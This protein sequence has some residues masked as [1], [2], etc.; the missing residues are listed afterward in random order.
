[1]N[2]QGKLEL[3]VQSFSSFM[4][5]HLQSFAAN[6]LT[7]EVVQLLTERG[8]MPDDITFIIANPDNSMG[9]GSHPMSRPTIATKLDRRSVDQFSAHIASML[10]G[11]T[12]AE[13][14]AATLRNLLGDGTP[15]AVP[16]A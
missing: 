12:D 2:Q 13:F 1:M 11:H 8:I 14:A 5:D 6:R 3:D 16:P 7:D 9:F 10:Q 4:Y 15:V